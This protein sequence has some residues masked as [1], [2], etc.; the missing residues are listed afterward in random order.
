MQH[1][2]SC[3]NASDVNLPVTVILNTSI[4]TVYFVLL[5]AHH[6]QAASP[7]SMCSMIEALPPGKYALARPDGAP[8]TGTAMQQLRF[9]NITL[10]LTLHVY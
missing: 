2:M 7:W 8:L 1:S 3:M 9:I 5:C 10:C 6:E 4:V